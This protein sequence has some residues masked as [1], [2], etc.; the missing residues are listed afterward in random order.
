MMKVKSRE[1]LAS[2]LSALFIA[3][4][5][6]LYYLLLVP[7][8]SYSPWLFGGL[9][10]LLV[11]LLCFLGKALYMRIREIKKEDVEDVTSKY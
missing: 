5:I 6:A 10:L 7:L 2:V 8:L 4:A 11:A 9:T 1:V 3:L